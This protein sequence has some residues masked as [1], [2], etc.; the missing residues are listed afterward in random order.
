[1]VF[2]TNL[3][4]SVHGISFTNNIP[5]AFARYGRSYNFDNVD[6]AHEVGDSK[7]L[8]SLFEEQIAIR[9]DLENL[10]KQR[11]V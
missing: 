4:W 1:M 10:Q 2:S 5:L 11:M 8:D 9:M 3:I 6:L 7:N